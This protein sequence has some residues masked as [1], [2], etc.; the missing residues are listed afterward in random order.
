VSA[1]KVQYLRENN[2]VVPHTQKNGRG[3]ACLYSEDDVVWLWIALVELDGVA[4]E[5]RREIIEQLRGDQGAFLGEFS[6]LRVR[7]KDVQNRI[8]SLLR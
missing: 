4:Y 1:R 5:K 2:I 8:K 3:K 6:E 7:I